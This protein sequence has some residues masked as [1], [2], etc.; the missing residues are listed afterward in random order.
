MRVRG[1]KGPRIRAAV[2]RLGSPLGARHCPGVGADLGR[3]QQLP[4]ARSTE[5]SFSP[6]PQG[7][8]HPCPPGQL[9]PRPP[10]LLHSH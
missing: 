3:A 8:L 10:S 2:L 1:V 7:Q 9:H 6:V 5:A 4:W